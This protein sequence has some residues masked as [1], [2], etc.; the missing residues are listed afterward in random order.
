MIIHGDETLARWVADRIPHVTEFV[1][2]YTAVGVV[3]DGEIVAGAIYNN[4]NPPDIH[5]GFASSHPRWA[6][7]ETIR[8]LLGWPF[9]AGCE[10]ITVIVKKA[11]SKTR[12]FVERLGFKMEGVHPKAFPNGATGLSYGLYNDVYKRKWLNA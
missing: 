4:F 11:D 12:R 5:M 7:K 8:V 6:S 3:R 10:R 2:P 9:D 1:P